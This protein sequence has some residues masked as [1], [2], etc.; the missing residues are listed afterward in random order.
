MKNPVF[1]VTDNIIR[2]FTIFLIPVGYLFSYMDPKTMV[3]GPDGDR[4]R[5]EYVKDIIDWDQEET[6]YD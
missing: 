6:T 1:F 5:W 3:H 2:C 4:T